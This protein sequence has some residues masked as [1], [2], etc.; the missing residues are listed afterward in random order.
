MS[1]IIHCGVSAQK[2]RSFPERPRAEAWTVKLQDI[3]YTLVAR[4]W[5]QLSFHLL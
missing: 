2:S 4:F 1:V 5:V 3:G